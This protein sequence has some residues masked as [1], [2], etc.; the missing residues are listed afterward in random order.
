MQHCHDIG[1]GAAPAPELLGKMMDREV[2]EGGSRRTRLKKRI[3]GKCQE[4]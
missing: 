4:A 2:R 1:I 3:F